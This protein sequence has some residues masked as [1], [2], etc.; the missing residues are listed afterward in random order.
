MNFLFTHRQQPDSEI[1]KLLILQEINSFN[2]SCLFTGGGDKIL[3]T[4]TKSEP[5]LLR[6]QVEVQTHFI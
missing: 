5:L 3:E 1:V 2:V 6:L 4:I